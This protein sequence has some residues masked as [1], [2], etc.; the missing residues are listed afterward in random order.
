MSAIKSISLIAYLSVMMLF[1]ACDYREIFMGTSPIV[2][3]KIDW[4]D[5]SGKE[6]PSG[7]SIYCYPKDGGL[8]Y[9]YK[10]NET[11][12][13]ETNLP[14]GTYDILVFNQVEE[15]F[16]NIA[17]SGMDHFETAKA[18]LIN[19]GRPDWVTGGENIVLNPEWLAI[20]RVCDYV[21]PNYVDP[22]NRELIINFKPQNTIYQAS[23]S[24]VMYRIDRI[25]ESSGTFSGLAQGIM[26]GSGD[27]VEGKITHLLNRININRENEN[28]S[29]KGIVESSF[30][31]MGP[32]VADGRNTK[33]EN[34][35]VHLRF[36][37]VDN[38][39]IADFIF[40]VGDC[41]ETSESEK[42]IDLNLGFDSD[43]PQDP[44]DNA[45]PKRPGILPDVYPSNLG[46]GFDVKVSSW[47]EEI[48]I[49]LKN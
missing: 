41:L 42:T 10:S 31:C 27:I 8:P 23:V 5:L 2:I 20:D 13:I 39:T 17:F 1:S 7:V 35:I 30:L 44:S 46:S 40:K 43:I 11:E 19:T 33:P 21:V 14:A 47:G 48:I 22:D 38:T 36:S 15:E 9:V 4:S 25:R 26:L 16:N 12:T 34:N 32:T 49:N 3:F 37:L 29:D 18:E 24:F 45:D 28:D 6:E